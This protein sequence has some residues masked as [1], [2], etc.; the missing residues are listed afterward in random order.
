MEPLKG[1]LNRKSR[2]NIQSSQQ[3]T[4]ESTQISRRARIEPVD[5]FPVNT[6]RPTPVPPSERD[7]QF[8]GHLGE[9][10]VTI[11]FQ[12]Q[13]LEADLRHKRSR[14]CCG[15]SAVDQRGGETGAECPGSER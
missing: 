9:S 11:R 6:F 4:R 1:L 10:W 14:G 7:I 13:D 3:P 8:L 15:K 2:Q 12:R 5:A